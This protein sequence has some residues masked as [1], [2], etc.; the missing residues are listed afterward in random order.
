M[1]KKFKILM[2][3]IILSLIGIVGVISIWLYGSYTNRLEIVTNEVERSLFNTVQKFYEKNESNIQQ[4]Q[5]KNYRDY[6]EADFIKDLIKLYPNIDSLKIK[7]L[8]NQF[9]KDKYAHYHS[10]KNKEGGTKGLVPPFVLQEVTFDDE[11]L[12]QIDSILDVSLQDK[13]ITFEVEVILV[14]LKEWPKA[15]GTKVE[16]DSLGVINSRPVLVNPTQKYF[17]KAKF[18][19]PVVYILSKMIWQLLVALLLVMA[20][21]GTFIY[22]LWTINRQNKLALLRKSFVNNMTHELKTPVAIVSAAIEAVQRYGAKDDKAKMERYLQ[23]SQKELAHL[24]NMIEKV[25]QLDV[26]EINGIVLEYE[27]ID[28]IALLKDIAALNKLSTKKPVYFTFSNTEAALFMQ[29]DPAHLKNVFNNLFDNA[30]KYSAEEVHIHIAVTKKNNLIIFEITDKGIGI[31]SNYQKDV[32]EMFFR[33]PNGDLHPVKGFGL[34]LAYVKQVVE[35]HG[36]TIHV[37]SEPHKGTTFTIS[38]PQ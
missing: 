10:N 31:A 35:S 19:P 12:A 33:V 36:G 32:F 37:N 28:V 29:G 16:I 13:G 7:E 24:T 20:L 27:Q 2:L 17:L 9:W 3:I 21:V 8:L 34:G 14:K 26:D 11:A 30:I 6:V 22:L 5:K 23:I 25:L 38:L 4:H 18:K 15:K 1:L